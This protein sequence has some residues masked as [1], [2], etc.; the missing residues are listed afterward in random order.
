[1]FVHNP[2]LMRDLPRLLRLAALELIAAVPHIYADIGGGRYF[3]NVLETFGPL[4]ADSGLVPTD[5]V[6][7]WRD[8]QIRAL[9][10]GTFFGASSFYT[11]L[12]RRPAE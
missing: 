4:L 9:A 7:R 5:E 3:A 8:W 6:E 12:A 1:V 2:R 10:E 11:Y